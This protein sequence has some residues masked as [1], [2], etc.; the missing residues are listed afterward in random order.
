MNVDLNRFF[1][2]PVYAFDFQLMV[3]DIGDFLEFSE[4][5]VEWQLRRELLS[6]QRQ[7]ETENLPA[8]YIEHLETN[9]K[10]RFSVSLPLRIRY[11]ALITLIT[12]V[13]WSVGFLS[14]QLKIPLAAK[15]KGR[16]E[17]VHTL[18]ELC[19]RAGVDERIALSDYEALVQVRNCIVHNAGIKQRYQHHGALAISVTRLKGFCLG[20]WHFFGE[21]I[22]I[23]KGALNPYINA[24]GQL[25]VALHK[26]CHS[27]GLVKNDT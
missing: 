20:N 22:C 3:G 10:H 8:G 17:T 6:I 14:K 21:H 11:G 5:N 24:M 13:E 4:S 9:T 27:Q 16:N 26:A 18:I 12:S 7:A 19:A 2:E 1:N 25:I 15:P 23:E